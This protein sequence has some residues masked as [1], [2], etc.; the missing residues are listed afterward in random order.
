[1]AAD[2]VANLGISLGIAEK[3]AGLPVESQAVLL[4][5]HQSVSGLKKDIHK[6]VQEL[7]NANL[8][9]LPEGRFRT[10]V[11]DAPWPV[12]RVP[13]RTMTVGEIEQ[14]IGDILSEKAADDC[15]MFLWT[16]QAHLFD[17]QK[18]IE[19]WGWKYICQM[20]WRKKAGRKHPDRPTYNFEIVLVA[21]KGSPAFSGTRQFLACF[22]GERREHSRKPDE[23]FEMIRRVTAGPRLE[24]FA[25]RPHDGF[26]P[27]G[28]EIDW[29]ASTE[30]QPAITVPSEEPFPSNLTHFDKWL[31]AAIASQNYDTLSLGLR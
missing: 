21:T 15:F 23:F 31:A 22:D 8:P 12:D 19:A 26:E 1:M 7:K 16:T 2:A 25:R 24:L 13:Y 3:L 4:A 11:V 29:S 14:S 17:A 18:M 6:A 10:I 27:Y 9:A 5:N 20:V 30:P 28:D